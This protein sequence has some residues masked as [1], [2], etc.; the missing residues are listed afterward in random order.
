MKDEIDKEVPIYLVQTWIGLIRNSE[1]DEV[2]KKRALFMLSE[3]IGTPEQ[4]LM[5]MNKNNII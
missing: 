3:K 1:I 5:F 2:V 4:V